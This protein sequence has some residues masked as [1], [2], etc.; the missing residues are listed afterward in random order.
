[1]LSWWGWVPNTYIDMVLI[2]NGHLRNVTGTAVGALLRNVRF[3]RTMTTHNSHCKN[4][5]LLVLRSGANA[6]PGVGCSYVKGWSKNRESQCKHPEVMVSSEEKT[7]AQSLKELESEFRRGC[8]DP[9]SRKAWLWGSSRWLTCFC[10]NSTNSTNHH[11]KNTTKHLNENLLNWESHNL[12]LKNSTHLGKREFWLSLREISSQ[13]KHWLL[14]SV[15]F[16]TNSSRFSSW[17]DNWTWC[18]QVTWLKLFICHFLT[19]DRN[20]QRASLL[21]PQICEMRFYGY[22]FRLGDRKADTH[23]DLQIT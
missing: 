21:P 17:P 16:R 8:W 12:I 19:P 11:Q 18:R 10:S 9:Q 7:H 23:K 1:M 22:Y 6:S 5:V 20:Q 13:R 14:Q 15:R 2:N 4:R 3:P